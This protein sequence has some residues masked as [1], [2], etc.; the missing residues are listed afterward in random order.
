MKNKSDLIFEIKKR[1][2]LFVLRSKMAGKE[3]LDAKRK[4]E[5][6]GPGSWHF[7]DWLRYRA[8]ARNWGMAARELRRVLL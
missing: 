5:A 1:V 7:D 2:T 3:A 4:Y 6:A 8:E